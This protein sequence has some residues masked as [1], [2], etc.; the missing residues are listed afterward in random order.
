MERIVIK[1]YAPYR[2]PEVLA[3]YQSVGWS[4]YYSQPD[5]LEQAFACSLCT[6]AAFDGERLV[7]LIR[8]VGDGHTVVFVQDILV[9]PQ[10]Q[11]RGIGTMLLGY[12]KERFSRV[13][14]MHLLTDDLPQTVGFYKAAGFTPVEEVRCRAFTRLRY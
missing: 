8:C 14:Q 7:G 4:A 13:R 6:L 9:H 1:D 2:A 3:L 12:V 11:R 10:Y 5:V